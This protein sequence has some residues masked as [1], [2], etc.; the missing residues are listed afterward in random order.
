MFSLGA[1][2]RREVTERIDRWVLNRRFGVPLFFL[3]MYFFLQVV[4]AVGGPA[5]LALE[6]LFSHIGRWVTANGP[7]ADGSL[8]LT[9][10]TSVIAGVGGVLAYTPNLFLLFFG[11]AFLEQSG[12]LARGAALLDRHMTRIGLSGGCFVP[13][14]LGFGC[15]VPAVMA[16]RAITN[17]RERIAAIMMLPFLS[18]SGRLPVY[19]LLVSAFFAPAWRPAALFGVYL[20]GTLAAVIFVLILRRTL[21]KGDRCGCLPV[22][23]EYVMPPLKDIL[24][25]SW[26]RGRHFLEKAGTTILIASILLGL[27]AAWPQ[28]GGTPDEQARGTLLGR[29]GTAVEPAF[30]LMGGDWRIADAALASLAAKEMFVSQAAILFS[31]EDSGVIGT[32]LSEKLRETYPPAA[33]LAFLIFILFSAPCVATFAA[34]KAETGSWKW[35]SAQYAGMT[36]LAYFAAVAVFQLARL[37]A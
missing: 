8:G 6:H 34:V 24:A 25:S 7:F 29:I 1:G 19:L 35:A 22:L 5:A 14:A 15:T 37:F 20:M 17:R 18:C 32:G 33:A 30:E 23:P 26:D 13:L 9:L 21:L 31:Q 11:M 27:L 2:S 36:L 3:C 10:V 16:T 4:F 28:V 12:Y